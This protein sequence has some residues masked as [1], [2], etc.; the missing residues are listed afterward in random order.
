MKEVGK[1]IKELRT[2]R[3]ITLKDLGEAIDFNYSNL[4]KIERGERK[5][6]IELLEKLSNFFNVEISYLFGTSQE[7]STELKDI[8]VEWISFSKEMQEKDISLDELKRMAETIAEIKKNSK[9]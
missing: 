8:G 5:P 3:G 1:R 7:P 6:T 9:E 2:K 4:S